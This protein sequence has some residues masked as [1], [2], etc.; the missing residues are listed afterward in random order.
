M[1]FPV[2]Q[3][4][5]RQLFKRAKFEGGAVSRSTP[6]VEV[7]QTWNNPNEVFVGAVSD[8]K[9]TQASQ[10]SHLQQWRVNGSNVATLS[11]FGKFTLDN[12]ANLGN[13]FTIDL[14]GGGVYDTVLSSG[15][16]NFYL[17]P[18]VGNGLNITGATGSL[19]L[20][21]PREQSLNI[22]VVPTIHD[23]AYGHINITARSQLPAATTNLKGRNV[24]LTGG[25]GASSSSG[26]AHGGDIVLTGGTGYGTGTKG[27]VTASRLRADGFATATTEKTADYTAT[28]DDGTIEVDA[29]GAARTI[30]LFAASGNAG[31]I[32]VVK[33]TDSSANAV[34]VDGNASET[35]DGATT[36][37]LASQ[38][39][40]AILQVNAAGTGWN[41]IGTGTYTV[42]GS[43][44][45]KT[46][47][48]FSPLA[49]Q[50]PA[51]SFAT[52]DTRNSVPVL[53]FDAAA[54]ESAV[55]S[56]TVPEGA[57]LTSGIV[58]NLVWMATSATSGNVRW[59]V[60]FER[61]TTDQD[62]DSFDTATEATD[63]TNGTS[64]ICETCEI[65]C[66]TIDSIVAGDSFRVRVTR[67]G[68]DATNDTMS[69]DAELVAVELRAA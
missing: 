27:I 4:R 45:T 60:A 37:S 23:D 32:I 55:F 10:S 57:S 40:T 49:N 17:R 46:L 7:V 18:A 24:T 56:A 31:K 11:R 43:G 50:P 20:S 61:R 68:T 39:S 67:V 5:L 29:S 48:V 14:G 65:T 66:T 59:R 25:N 54:D 64:G 41:T 26:A 8:F 30:T 33:K 52:L 19:S 53:D 35:I 58:V 44:G 28:L 12:S 63:A 15:G 36:I 16:I 42:G 69:G 6:V 9:V 38:Y 62:A 2:F 1:T 13:L 22:G 51:S 47:A 3:G 21:A 34:T